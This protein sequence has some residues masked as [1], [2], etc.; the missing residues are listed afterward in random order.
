M[1][2]GDAFLHTKAAGAYLSTPKL[3][4]LTPE[5]LAEG[6]SATAFCAI[7]HSNLQRSNLSRNLLNSVKSTFRIKQGVKLCCL[8]YTL[9]TR[10]K[11]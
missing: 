6:K 7:R 3:R 11:L 9:K 5:A 10:E 4:K 1:H 8:F 2:L